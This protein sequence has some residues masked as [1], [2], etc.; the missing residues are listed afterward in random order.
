MHNA[1]KTTGKEHEGETALGQRTAAEG[2]KCKLHLHTT[3]YDNLAQETH[4]CV[5]L[6]NYQLLKKIV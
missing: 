3:W 5:H 4:C 2:M 6:S 1:Y